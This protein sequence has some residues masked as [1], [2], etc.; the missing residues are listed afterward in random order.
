MRKVII[1]MTLVLLASGC[2]DPLRDVP[3]LADVPVEAEAGQADVLATSADT[4]TLPAAPVSDTA[5]KRGLLGFLKGKADAV[6]TP[7]ADAAQAP[8][9]DA[10]QATAA[11]AAEDGAATD[12]AV[13]DDLADVGSSPDDAEVVVVE[14]EEQPRRRGLFGLGGGGGNDVQLAA[15]TTS[16]APRVNRRAAPRP[17]APDA[18]EIAFGTTLPYGQ[19]ARV[20]GVP[21][22]KLGPVTQTWPERGRGYELH[23][24]APGS[25]GAH[26]FY[27]TG[28]KDGCARQFTAAL[29]IFGS[30]ESWEQ[31]HYGPAGESLP[32]LATDKAYEGVK[33]KVCRVGKGKPCGSRMRA[34]EKDTVFVSVYERF[35]DN[36]RWKNILLHDGEVVAMDMKN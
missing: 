3:R 36:T 5:P 12:E 26:T 1:G 18:R 11:V 33:S 35:E 29:V 21:G 8:V 15:A 25:T 19:I 30:P 7:A 13:A 9:G 17:G 20:C 23:D 27:M 34:L 10:A 28:F 24:S 22:A 16:G 2:G 6:R 32:V 31:I 14:A 4:E